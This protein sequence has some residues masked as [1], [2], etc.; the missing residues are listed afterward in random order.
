MGVTHAGRG[1]QKPRVTDRGML[2]TEVRQGEDTVWP[3]QGRKPCHVLPRGGTLKTWCSVKRA[4]HERTHVV[5][6]RVFEESRLGQ[7]VETQRRLISGCL[8]LEKMGRGWGGD[9]SGVGGVS[10]KRRKRSKI[11]RG[12]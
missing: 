1:G 3:Q 12:H 7:S 6:F 8:E 9:D 11:E 4:R 10:L 2:C 5:R